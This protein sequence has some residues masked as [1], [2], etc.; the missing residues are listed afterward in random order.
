MS[1]KCS[2][3]FRFSVWAHPLSSSSSFASEAAICGRLARRPFQQGKRRAQTGRRLLQFCVE[4]CQRSIFAGQLSENPHRVA[5][6]GKNLRREDSFIGLFPQSGAERQQMSRKVAAVHTGNIERKERS[7]RARV[8]PVVEM[9]AMPFESLHGGEGVLR[10]SNQAAHRKIPKIP[11]GQ[12]GE[13]RQAH[14][15]GRGARGDRRGGNFLKIVRR[16]PVLLRGDKGFEKMPRL[17]G[18]ASAETSIALP[19]N[20]ESADSMGWLIHQAIHGA[21]SQRP[22]IGRAKDS[23]AGCMVARKSPVASATT[24]AIHIV[25]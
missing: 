3:Q 11:G 7:Q 5:Q 24:G 12:I 2:S 8:I 15:R 10:A 16:Q 14:V 9:P 22:R 23:W 4:L 25:A 17:A 1:S 18:G 19:S 6:T 21:A 20:P 13:Q